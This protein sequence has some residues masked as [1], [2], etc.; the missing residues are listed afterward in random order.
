MSK[1]GT[2]ASCLD[3]DVDKV[4]K[5]KE[6]LK[7]MWLMKQDFVRDF[8]D[9]HDFKLHKPKNHDVTMKLELGHPFQGKKIL[10]WC[11]DKKDT[12]TPIVQ[13]ARKAYGKFENSGVAK[14]T[15]SGNVVFHFECPQL[16][17]ANKTPKSKSTTFFRHLHFVVEVDGQ[18]GSQIYTKIVVCDYTYKRFN[19][20]VGSGMS[21]VV[22]ALPAEYYAKDHVP[23]SYNLFYKTIAKMSTKE[24]EDWFSEVVKIHY[25]KLATYVKK[26]QLDIYEIPIVTYCAHKKCNASELAMKELMKKGFVNV[27]EYSGGIQEYR[28]MVPKD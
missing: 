21:V 7:P 22:N 5:S 23:N 4:V 1:K 17:K 27:N 10:Y 25:P 13:D 16:Y 14:S 8:I 11:S 15:A 12:D 3:F 28:K 2:C 18:W 9:N 19:E 26:K 6:T 24:L 20:L